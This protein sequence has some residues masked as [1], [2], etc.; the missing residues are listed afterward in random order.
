MHVSGTLIGDLATKH[1]V[2]SPTLV[3]Q[4]AAGSRVDQ[5]DLNFMSE[6]G[7]LQH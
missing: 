7:K 5:S 1:C 2:T 3:D 4:T 6:S